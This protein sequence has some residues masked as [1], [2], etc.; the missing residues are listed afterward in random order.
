MRERNGDSRPTPLADVLQAYLKRAGLVRRMGQAGVIEEWVQLVGPQIA[1]VTEPESVTPEG[2]LR[3]RVATAAW[4]SELQLMTP[5]IL[6]RLNTG[7][8][9][10]ITAVRWVAGGVEGHEGGSGRTRQR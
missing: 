2:V 10:R 6:A 4:A 8:A 3:V 9:G 7:R 5:Q 1:S